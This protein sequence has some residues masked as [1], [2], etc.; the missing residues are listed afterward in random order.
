MFERIFANTSIPVLEEVMAF[1]G[2]RHRYLANNVANVDTP[3]YRALD[4]PEARF[5]RLLAEA[6]ERRRRRGGGPLALPG[7]AFVPARSGGQLR[8][9][10][11][12]VSLDLELARMS[13]NAMKFQLAARLLASRLRFLSMVVRERMR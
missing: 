5:Q 10:G 6:V 2:L 4:L 3:G 11:N 12:D 8:L 9:D 13:K 7:E 1:A